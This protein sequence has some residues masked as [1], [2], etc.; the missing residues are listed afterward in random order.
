MIPIVLQLTSGVGS[1]Y[2]YY[3]FILLGVALFS[4]TLRAILDYRLRA[5]RIEC[6]NLGDEWLSLE[7]NTERGQGVRL[8]KN[9]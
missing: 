3:T 7:L 2:I 8:T 1:E 6:Q 5:K 9:T 4:F